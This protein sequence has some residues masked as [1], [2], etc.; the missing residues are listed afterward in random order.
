MKSRFLKLKLFSPIIVKG[1]A[2]YEN[3]WDGGDDYR[4]LVETEKRKCRDE[5]YVN[6]CESLAPIVLPRS[7]ERRIFSAVPVVEEKDEKLMLSLS[8]ECYRKLSET[9]IDE[10]C[11]WWENRVVEVNENLSKKKIKTK[12]FGRIIIYLWFMKG[13]AIEPVF[14]ARQGGV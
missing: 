6:V 5:I 2:P 9:E 10:L 8:C 13:W 1:E 4:V 7:F 12:R 14:P 11:D 3:P